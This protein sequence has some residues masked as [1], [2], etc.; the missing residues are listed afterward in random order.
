M[1]DQATDKRPH[2]VLQN[3]SEAIGFTAH[4]PN[5]GPPVVIPDL[6]RHQHGQSLQG[7]LEALR[8][9]AAGSRPCTERSPVGRR[10]R[11]TN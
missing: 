2:F 11:V 7:Q 1:P 8:P 10:Y 5:G 6:P 9:A 4:S 3:T